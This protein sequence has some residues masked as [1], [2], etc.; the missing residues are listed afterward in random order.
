MRV[1]ITGGGTGG[2]IYPDISI[3][4]KLK[5]EFKDIDIL[6]I[7]TNKGL[8][9]ELVPKEGINFKTITVTGFQRKISPE[10]IKTINNLIKGLKQSR[11]I[12][13]SF[14]PDFVIGT[15]GYVCGPVVLM[16]SLMKIKTAIHEQNVIPG[17]TN[18]ILSKFVDRIYISF[19][20]SKKYFNVDSNKIVFTG[21]PIREE[22]NI[23]MGH[24]VAEPELRVLSFGGSRGAK[25]INETIRDS[26]SYLNGM[27]GIRLNHIK[28]KYYYY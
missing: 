5:Q 7:G 13:K 2:H 26:L 24:R 8:E 19:D 23:D 17:A 18:R 1:L 9:R 28:G 12:I 16:A 3:A 22:F 14:K 20:E 21:N 15:G 4:K 10:L 6:Y 27:D 11:Q 25:K